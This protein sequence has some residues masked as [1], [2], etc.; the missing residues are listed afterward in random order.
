MKKF[1]AAQRQSGLILTGLAMVL[2]FERGIEFC[3]VLGLI[4]GC[5]LMF[6]KEIIMF[7]QKEIEIL[8]SEEP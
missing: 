8:N 2:M 4:L 7:T 1:F 6:S 5:T 3:S